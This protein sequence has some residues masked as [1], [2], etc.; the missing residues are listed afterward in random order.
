MG[1]FLSQTNSFGQSLVSELGREGAL[2]WRLYLREVEKASY[3][4]VGEVE[5]ASYLVVGE[6]EKAS[7][8]VV[9]G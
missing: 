5:K 6:V 4:V 8:L 3:L 7:Y 1:Q 2:W 9:R